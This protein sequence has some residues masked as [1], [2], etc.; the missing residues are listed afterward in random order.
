MF[1]KRERQGGMEEGSRDVDKPYAFM[2]SLE[3]EAPCSGLDL[4]GKAIYSK[5][6]V[7]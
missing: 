7:F 4:S 1:R 2:C 5:P 3:N 6:K